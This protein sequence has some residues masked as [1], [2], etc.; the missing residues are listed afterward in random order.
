MSFKQVSS[1][2]NITSKQ[3]ISVECTVMC[4][5]VMSYQFIASS[6]SLSI[7]VLS[8]MEPKGVLVNLDNVGG[9]EMSPS[10]TTIS[11]TIFK[12]MLTLALIMLFLEILRISTSEC[13]PL[14]RIKVLS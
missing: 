1:W 4:K 8:K 7:H 2:L 6:K 5:I 9:H 14:L 11:S 13:V 10:P 12:L 3:G